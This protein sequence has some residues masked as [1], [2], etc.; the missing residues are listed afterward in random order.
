MSVMKKI[1]WDDRRA[2]RR[3]AEEG[4]INRSVRKEI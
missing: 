3:Q 1:K 2:I 4:N